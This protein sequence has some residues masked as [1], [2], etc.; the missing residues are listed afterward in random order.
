MSML[1]RIAIVVTCVLMLVFMAGCKPNMYGASWDGLP[2]EQAHSKLIAGEYQ[3][4]TSV[5]AMPSEL[6]DAFR[7][8]ARQQEFELAEPGATDGVERKLIV[9]GSSPENAFVEYRH[10]ND[11]KVVVF[12]KNASKFEFVWGGQGTRNTADVA[13]LKRLIAAGEF[14]DDQPYWW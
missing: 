1:R 5:S 3:T 11:T 10:G 7:R 2:R 6:Q 8:A 14:K 9:W 12:R 4:S 13:E